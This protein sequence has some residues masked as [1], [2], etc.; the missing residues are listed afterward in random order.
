[1]SPFRYAPGF[2]IVPYDDLGALEKVFAENEHIVGV[3]LE[4]IQGEAGIMIP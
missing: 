2:I 4:P 1:M 3:C